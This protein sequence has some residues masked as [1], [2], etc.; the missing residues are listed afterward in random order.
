LF[1]TGALGGSESVV[2]RHQFEFPGPGVPP[3][4]NRPRRVIA[5]L[6]HILGQRRHP[7]LVQTLA[8]LVLLWFQADAFAGN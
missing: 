2:P 5:A 8:R 3:Y 7:C 4:I 6:R 1:D